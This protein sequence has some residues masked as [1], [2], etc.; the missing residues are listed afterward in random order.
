MASLE[1]TGAAAINKDGMPQDGIAKPATKSTRVVHQTRQRHHMRRSA[2]L[3]VRLL[4]FLDP[5][6]VLMV[7]IDVVPLGVGA[8]I[9]VQATAPV[10][11]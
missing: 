7:F 2:L 9:P 8:G 1:V 10:S 4:S 11:S 6:K 5:L 3:L